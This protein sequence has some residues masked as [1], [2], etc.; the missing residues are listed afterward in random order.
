MTIEK[1]VQEQLGILVMQLLRASVQV[2]NLQEKVVELTTEVEKLKSL[3]KP[4]RNPDNVKES[5]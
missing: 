2:D 4:V 3:E 5:K 1:A